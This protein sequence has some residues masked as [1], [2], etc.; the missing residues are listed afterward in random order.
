[1]KILFFAR[2]KEQLGE[3]CVEIADG[4][5]PGDV[6]GLRQLLQLSVNQELAESLAD[7][8]VFC[9]VNQK[10]VGEEHPLVSSDEVAFFPPMTGG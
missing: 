1:M 6:A 3:D 5:C 10:V 7:P 4:D 9:A 2:L 8:N